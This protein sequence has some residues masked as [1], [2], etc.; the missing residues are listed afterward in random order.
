[1]FAQWKDSDQAR[2]IGVPSSE[3]EKKGIYEGDLTGR[4]A[5][6]RLEFMYEPDQSE[7][8]SERSV[9][10][11]TNLINTEDQYPI[12]IT[13]NAR[14]RLWVNGTPVHSG[15]AKGDSYVQYY[16]RIDLAPWLEEGKNVLAV[17]VLWQ[18][19]SAVTEQ[20]DQR[21]AIVGVVNQM[22]GHRLLVA[23]KNVTTGIADWKVFLDGSRYLV[24]D[25][26]T[27]NLGS[28]IEDIDFHKVPV[29]WK[30]KSYVMSS[31]DWPKAEK[32]EKAVRDDFRQMV[33]L[34]G[35]FHLE[36][37]PIPLMY[38][39]LRDFDGEFTQTG[40][41]KNGFCRI[42]KHLSNAQT[43]VTID[44][45][46]AQQQ[47]L[48]HAQ[49]D[50]VIPVSF[51]TAFEYYRACEVA[52]C[53]GLTMDNLY[54]WKKLLDQHCTTCPEEPV[55]ARSECHGWSA[56][57]IYEFI[58]TIA[59]IRTADTGDDSVIIQPH[60]QT[61]LRYMQSGETAF[62]LAAGKVVTPQGL[63]TFNYRYESNQ[64]QYDITLPEGLKGIFIR[65]DGSVTAL[66][67]GRQM[68]V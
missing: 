36:E 37:R 41:L 66:K 1:M 25:E 20:Y 28:V 10:G 13:A 32:K 47:I 56:L 15:P 30:K 8:N 65:E 33:G 50:D 42:Q 39:K 2:W 51:S 31:Y 61:L 11:E 57:P 63:I 40:I 54:R 7:T 26:T 60:L 17:Q 16:D 34:I 23:G 55:N 19:P 24:C 4:F 67:P 49:A 12:L 45:K 38:E 14:Y 64:I 3:Y 6:Y 62:T 22:G 29:G 44:E 43:I 35:K 5:L 46:T 53:Y 18:N 59:G 27:E 58:R 52:G 9:K 48:I 21:T 68:F